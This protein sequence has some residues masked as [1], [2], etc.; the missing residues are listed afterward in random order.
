MSI[1][2]PDRSYLHRHVL[3]ELKDN[4]F[5]LKRIRNDVAV[6]SVVIILI[7]ELHKPTNEVCVGA[8]KADE[9]ASKSSFFSS[10]EQL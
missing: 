5:T 7:N 2:S 4:F 10:V 1:H 3:A 8:I 6:A 9:V